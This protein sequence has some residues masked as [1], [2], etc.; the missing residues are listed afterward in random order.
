MYDVIVVGGGPA[1]LNAALILGRCRRPVVVYDT[2]HPRNARSAALHSGALHGFLSAPPRGATGERQK[3]SLIAKLGCE[4]DEKGRTDTGDFEESNVSGLCVAGDA[5]DDIQFA[6][7]AAAR[8]PLWRST[9]RC[10]VRRP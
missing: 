8:E 10:C 7:V 3:S 9:K 5:S 4:L 1:G 6:I 2:G